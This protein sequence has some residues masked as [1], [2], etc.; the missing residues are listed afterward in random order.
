MIH[1]IE[2]HGFEVLIAYYLAISVFGTM[3]PLPDSASYLAKWGFAAAHALCG[4]MKQMIQS[5]P[6]VQPPK[7]S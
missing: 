5:I 6:G 3:P 4:N 7:E 1:W 2:T